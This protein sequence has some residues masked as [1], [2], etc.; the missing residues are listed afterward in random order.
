MDAWLGREEMLSVRGGDDARAVDR[1]LA[2]PRKNAFTFRR[3][4]Q[5]PRDGDFDQFRWIRPDPRHEESIGLTA[6]LPRLEVGCD[7]AVDDAWSK[8]SNGHLF[9]KQLETRDSLCGVEDDVCLSGEKVDHHDIRTSDAP[10]NH[11]SSTVEGESNRGACQGR[12]LRLTEVPTI[13]RESET[14]VRLC[15]DYDEATPGANCNEPTVLACGNELVDEL[16]RASVQ[17]EISFELIARRRAV[18]V[19]NHLEHTVPVCVPA[20]EAGGNPPPPETR[21]LQDHRRVESERSRWWGRARAQVRLRMRTRSGSAR[22]QR[23]GQG[24]ETHR[25][26]DHRHQ[27]HSATGSLVRPTCQV[28]AALVLP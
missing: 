27:T 11:G 28:P 18:K 3:R 1:A 6:A 17:E 22:D 9:G 12:T 10:S 7:G 13:I 15:I 2:L 4:I 5:R 25:V 23:T 8:Q 21:I 20:G 19:T 16:R 14:P 26:G 24:E